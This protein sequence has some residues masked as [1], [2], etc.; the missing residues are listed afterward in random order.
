MTKERMVSRTRARSP[1]DM[2]P[3]AQDRSLEPKWLRKINSNKN[4]TS[5]TERPAKEYLGPA[6]CTESGSGFPT[7]WLISF[8]TSRGVLNAIPSAPTTSLNKTRRCAPPESSNA[9]WQAIA[10][11]AAPTVIIT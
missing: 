8:S 10:T 1:C 9:T 4:R 2:Q 11:N 5:G 3:K 7:G 6:L